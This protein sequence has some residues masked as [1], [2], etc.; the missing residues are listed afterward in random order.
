VLTFVEIG[1]MRLSLAGKG[2]I[3]GRAYDA[4]VGRIVKL[5]NALGDP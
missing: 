2:H 4:T 3:N 1:H 5:A